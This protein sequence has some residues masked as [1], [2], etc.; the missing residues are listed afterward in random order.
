LTTSRRRSPAQRR[1]RSPRRASRIERRAKE[2]IVEQH[3]IDT[4]NLLSSTQ[5]TVD[6][7]SAEVSVPVDYAAAQEFG[8]HSQPA[9]PFLT[10]AFEEV[11]GELAQK[12]KERIEGGR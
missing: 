5:S 2:L 9:R 6:G 7:M 8:T 11:T 1:R 10:P 12:I 3:I 4:G